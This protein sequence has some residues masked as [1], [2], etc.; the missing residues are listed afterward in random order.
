MSSS[1]DDE[2]NSDEFPLMDDLLNIQNIIS[3]TR[4]NMDAL[5]DKIG[6]F[7]NPPQLY[8][9]EFEELESKL[10]ELRAKESDLLDRIQQMEDSGG[11]RPYDAPEEEP[12]SL[13]PDPKSRSAAGDTSDYGGVSGGGGGGGGDEKPKQYL[14]RAYLPNKQRTSVQVMPGRKLRD[15]LIKALRRRNMHCEM[16]EVTT[17]DGN[18]II[19]WDMDI[20]LIRAKEV[21][22]T[23]MEKFPIISQISHQFIR[24]TFFSLAFCECCRRLLFTG[25]YCNQ[26]NFRFHQRCADKV[27]ETP[28][29]T[30]IVIE[31]R[32]IPLSGA[33]NVQDRVQ[34]VLPVPAR[35][36]P[37]ELCQHPELRRDAGPVALAV[38]AADAEP[39]GPVQFGTQRVHKQC[40]AP[41]LDR[42]TEA[43]ATV[44]PG[45]GDAV[46]QLLADE[47]AGALAVH[48]GLAH[49]HVA[50]EA[51][52]GTVGG[53]E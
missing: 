5:N 38:P 32:Q 29:P 43:A 50:S 30:A 18:E 4:S 31:T 14:L 44:Q 3:V 20:S 13:V 8:V 2:N 25:F 48:A 34:H 49:K 27:S 40:E 39:T 28:A 52:E 45:R 22:V 16:C 53:R 37:R 46:L 51:T 15:A 19:P 24:K 6:D 10:E 41:G 47:P 21:Q 23:V 11:R 7:P 26:C 35:P 36:E 17:V 9:M 42:A 33:T 12:D 1:T